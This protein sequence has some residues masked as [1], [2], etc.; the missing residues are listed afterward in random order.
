V[1]EATMAIVSDSYNYFVD[2]VAERR[3]LPK[4]YVTKVADGRIYTG[5]QALELK[6]V[7]RLGGVDEALQWLKETK[8][9]DKNLKVF[10]VELR[11][12]SLLQKMLGDDVEQRICSM[13][14][15][16]RGLFSSI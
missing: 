12:K 10:E 16:M 7:D 3:K 14:F 1:E 8:S 4:E 9:I 6:L 2:I 15:N 5:R 11:P 13:F